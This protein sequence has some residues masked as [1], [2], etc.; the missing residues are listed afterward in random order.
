M[1]AKIERPVSEFNSELRLKGFNVWQLEADS[2]ATK[3]YNRK[4]D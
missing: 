3:I 1:A 2:Q 4:L